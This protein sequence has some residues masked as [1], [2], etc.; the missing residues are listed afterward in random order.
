M[1]YKVLVETYEKLEST[2]K[3]LEKTYYIAEL[4]KNTSKEDLPKVV[5]LLQGKAFPNWDER[6]IGIASRLVIKAIAVATGISSLKI[7]QEWKKTGDLGT[8]AENIIKTKKQSTLFSQKLTVAKVFDNVRKLSEMEGSGSVERKL[9]LISEL[10]TSSTPKEACYIART[11]LEDL[12]VGVG[13]GSLRDAIAWA[14]FED[15]IVVK[16]HKDEKQIEVK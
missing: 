9:A 4:L 13:E 14:F 11:L 5:L 3:R 16:Y 12:R 7:E 10:L 2:S 6:K 8:V 15:K 1:D